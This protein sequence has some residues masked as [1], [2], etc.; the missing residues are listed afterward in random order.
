MNAIVV[1]DQN[2][3]IGQQGQLLFRLPSDLKR[4]RQLTL[5]STILMGCN[6]LQSLPGARPLPGRENVVL[7]SKDLDLPGATILH[8]PA[9]ALALLGE[10]ENVFVIGGGSVYAS[11]L[12]YCQRAFVTRVDAAAAGADTFFPN[13]DKLPNWEIEAVG[14]PQADSGLHFRYYDYVNRNI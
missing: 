13:L 4:F 9:E 6:T 12:P 10:K 2:W 5:G 14:E 7:T 3:G 11:F 8:T 1:V